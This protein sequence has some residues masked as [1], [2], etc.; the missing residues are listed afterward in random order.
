[1]RSHPKVS[2]SDT[3]LPWPLGR[4]KKKVPPGTFITNSNYDAVI[5]CKIKKSITAIGRN[6]ENIL[7]RPGLCHTFFLFLSQSTIFVA[8]GTSGRFYFGSFRVPRRWR[9]AKF[10]ST[11]LVEVGAVI[12]LT[13]KLTKIFRVAGRFASRGRRKIRQPERNTSLRNIY[14]CYYSVCGCPSRAFTVVAPT[15]NPLPPDLSGTR[16][17]RSFF[18]EQEAGSKSGESRRWGKANPRRICR[19][20]KHGHPAATVKDRGHSG[21]DST[22]DRPSLK[23]LF[24]PQ[25]E[26][27]SGA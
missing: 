20:R 16:Q 27:R 22:L 8:L 11:H 25:R 21:P 23:A 18:A 24:S 2:R 13:A 12:K 6:N 14:A 19:R 7:L 5:S 10:G 1:M 9:R 4:S 15:G 26:R 17:E 3:H